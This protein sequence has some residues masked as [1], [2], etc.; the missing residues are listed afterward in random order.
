MN[1]IIIGIN[2]SNIKFNDIE[3]IMELIGN[4]TNLCKLHLC[5]ISLEPKD[6]KVVLS[7]IS[8]MNCITYLDLSN[9]TFEGS[10]KLGDSYKYLSKFI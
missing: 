2:I 7:K 10:N 9:K 3:Q 8:E 1:D 4:N 5:N 6:F